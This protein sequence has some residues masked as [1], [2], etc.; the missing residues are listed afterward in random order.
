MHFLFFVVLVYS[1]L[2]LSAQDQEGPQLPVILDHA[3]SLVGIGPP[4]SGVREFWGN[5][6]FTQGNVTITCDRAVYTSSTNSAELFGRVIVHQ[7]NVLV[8]APFISY[9]GETHIADASRG[10]KV[11][12][13]ASII[14]ADK[15]Q[16]ST[17]THVS[18]FIDH[19][20]AV[21]DSIRI[22]SD[23][24]VFDRDADTSLASGRVVISDSAGS[25]WLSGDMAFRDNRSRYTRISGHA[26][27]WQ[28]DSTDHPD[29][30][31][32]AADTLVMT[33]QENENGY[34][35][36]SHV[37]LV[38]SSVS[39]LADTMLYSSVRGD[40]DLRGHPILWSDS[41]LLVADT[42]NALAPDRK[43]SS[44]I[45]RSNALLVSRSDT[46]NLDRFDQISGESIVLTIA[47]DTVRQ[48][49]AIGRAQSITFRS[50]GT[51]PEGLAKVASDTIRAMF[52]QGQ[53]TDVYW[54][55]GIEG[56]HHPEPVVAGRADTYRLP[57]FVWRTDRPF[58]IKPVAPFTATMTKAG[59][60]PKVKAVNQRKR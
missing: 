21:D 38:R 28:W 46:L 3:D 19:A 18:T 4:E 39:A 37:R 14:T 6:R 49:S 50:D 17:I 15:G 44:V 25:A 60:P 29:T 24:L 36:L 48:L 35:A 33:R 58:M 20:I 55:G 11:E 40:F 10:I 41:L 54:L 9:N 22:W 52:Q 56:E 31:Y 34:V 13:G 59:D 30:I 57:G 2:V 51:R 32:V 43:L 7:G 45:G 42:I 53:L 8:S 47:D 12:E 16:Y 1:S 27:A 26:A 23:T 5:V